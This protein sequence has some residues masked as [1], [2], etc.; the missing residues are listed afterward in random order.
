MIIKVSS[1]SE[2]YEYL[3]KNPH[4][5]ELFKQG[6]WGGISQELTPDCH[7]LLKVKCKNCGYETVFEFDISSTFPPELVEKLKKIGKA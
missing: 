3:R 2:E 5:C 7:D 4:K 6:E 1:I